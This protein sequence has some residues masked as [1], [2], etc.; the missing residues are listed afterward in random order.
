MKFFRILAVLFFL[1]IFI[2]ISLADT[3]LYYSGWTFKSHLFEKSILKFKGEF[4]FKD[5]KNYYRKFYT[6]LSKKVSSKIKLGFFI[7]RKTK[8]DD[9]W[10][11]ENYIFPEFSYKTKLLG[12]KFENRNRIEYFFKS[13]KYTY[14]TRVKFFRQISP[15]I[16]IWFGDE[17]RFFSNVHGL[18]KNE[19]LIGFNLKVS[20]KLDIDFYYDYLSEKID[21]LWNNKNIFRTNFTLFF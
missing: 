2:N 16:K 14:R 7:A 12:F 1:L 21:N 20:K 13:K 6:G 11:G 9:D 8:K 17:I 5:Y 18:A 15:K 19:I 10:N 4:R 3:F